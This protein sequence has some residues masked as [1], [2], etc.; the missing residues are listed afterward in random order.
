MSTRENMIHHAIGDLKTGV[1]PSQNAA[2]DAYG[3]AQV[4]TPRTH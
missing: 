3:F 4:Y 2:A 1:L